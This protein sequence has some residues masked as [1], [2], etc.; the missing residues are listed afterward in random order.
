MAGAGVAYA[1]QSPT[2]AVCPYVECPCAQVYAP[3]RTVVVYAPAEYA[4][5][6]AEEGP[7]GIPGLGVKGLGPYFGV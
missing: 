4:D 1:C 5:A 6:R 7:M 2:F 3:A